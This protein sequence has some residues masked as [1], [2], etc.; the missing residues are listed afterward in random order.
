MVRMT[1]KNQ[2][3]S[4]SKNRGT[5]IGRIPEITRRWASHRGDDS[6]AAT[7]MNRVLVA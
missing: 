1:L 6:V 2:N 5:T 3:P 4:F 7:D